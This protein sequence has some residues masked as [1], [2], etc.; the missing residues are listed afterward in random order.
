M[1]GTLY[2]HSHHRHLSIVCLQLVES[3]DSDPERGG[4]RIYLE[5]IPVDFLKETD[6]Q[7]V[8]SAWTA[9][10]QKPAAQF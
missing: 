9:S 10:V 1:T 6:L 5:S 4:G 2:R 3:V 8:R 7:V